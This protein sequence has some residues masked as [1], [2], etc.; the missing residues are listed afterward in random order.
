MKWKFCMG[1]PTLT[2]NPYLIKASP[3]PPMLNNRN[4]GQIF[5]ILLAQGDNEVSKQV[6]EKRAKFWST[7]V[8][9]KLT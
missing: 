7:V 4:E 5:Q 1:R 3:C 8:D 2:P 6:I 9:V